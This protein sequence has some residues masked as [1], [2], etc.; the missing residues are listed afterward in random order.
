MSC[1]PP[2]SGRAGE[3]WA[4]FCMWEAAALV[5]L[6]WS[7]TMKPQGY[8]DLSSSLLI[9]VLSVL[10]GEDEQQRELCK[11]LPGCVL[12][13]NTRNVRLWLLALFYVPHLLSGVSFG[14]LACVSCTVLLRN[15]FSHATF[16][17]LWILWSFF[18]QWISLD[19]MLVTMHRPG[20]MA[21]RLGWLYNA[22][23]QCTRSHVGTICFFWVWTVGSNLQS[24]LWSSAIFIMLPKACEWRGSSTF[25]NG[26]K[27]DFQFWVS[28]WILTSGSLPPPIILAFSL[29]AWT[30]ESVSPFVAL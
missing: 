8:L 5:Q 7:S 4:A 15:Q 2:E 27:N 3:V 25:I 28:A 10:P 19:G 17:S 14:Y 30:R 29:P 12:S 23:L 26:D 16:F 20:G 1:P 11:Q 18:Q 22:L 13:V 24:I 21:D 9:P 6:T